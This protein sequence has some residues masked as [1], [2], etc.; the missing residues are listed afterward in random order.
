[1][2]APDAGHARAQGRPYPAPKE[3]AAAYAVVAS[4]DGLQS[5]WVGK[6]LECAF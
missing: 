2:P 4:L 3:E 5:K 6:E 1:M